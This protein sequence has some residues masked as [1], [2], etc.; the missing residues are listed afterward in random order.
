MQSADRKG[1][2]FLRSCRGRGLCA[3]SLGIGILLAM[4]LPIGV[5]MFVSALAMILLGLAW[6]RKY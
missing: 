2:G 6:M 3:I 4:V 5:I 1:G